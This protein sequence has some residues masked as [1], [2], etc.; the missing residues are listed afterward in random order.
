MQ[1][2]AAAWTIGSIVGCASGAPWWFWFLALLAGSPWLMV[3]TMRRS[4]AAAALLVACL[5]MSSGRAARATQVVSPIDIRCWMGD[6]QSGPARLR[7]RV[8]SRRGDGR[9]W[10][11]VLRWHV[12][13]VQTSVTAWHP[14]SGRV[15]LQ[16]D[17][18]DLATGSVI[19][20]SGR[21]RT[22]LG[23]DGR[24][25]GFEVFSRSHLRYCQSPPP[26]RR[27]LD[28]VRSRVYRSLLAPPLLEGTTQ[29]MVSAIVLGRRDG[30]WNE[31]ATPFRSTGT[32]HLLAVSGLHLAVLCGLVLGASRW[33]GASMR[34]GS[35]MV[36]LVT[37]VMLMVAQVRTPLARAGLM[38][39]VASG[40]SSLRWR[41][42]AGSVLA[43]AAM[44]IEIENPRAVTDV[45]FQLSFAV[46]AG[47]IYLFPIWSRRVAVVG[48]PRSLLVESTRAT[49][50]AWLVA[51][52]IAA[53]HFGMYSLLGIP[54]TLLL[55]PVVAGVLVA[56]YLRILMSW[57]LM[58]SDAAG[59]VLNAL[60][61]VL[62]TSVT[63]LDHLPGSGIE[64]TPPSWW[65]VLAAESAG[66]GVMLA[67]RR[68][69]RTLSL[70]VM[71]LLWVHAS[72]G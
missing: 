20:A 29:S 52:P 43:L 25:V 36:V 67:T 58:A 38:V 54:A 2:M 49:T 51:T 41:L 42:S 55:F 40:L 68:V 48:I 24:L 23:R 14:A 17:L 35:V 60:A 47:L 12:D 61:W 6:S 3:A 39:L 72:S 57:W 32:A 10:C 66:I 31:V 64:M 53:H 62:W 13:D 37:A 34:R 33:C 46:V 30:L 21:C 50:T 65:W 56:G 44:A 9:R 5:L 26:W 16:I 28:G 59:H 7:L 15:L 22:G 1:L 19:E 27:G 69:V 71:V 63:M 8:G 45:G 4:V 18:G 11:D 70:V